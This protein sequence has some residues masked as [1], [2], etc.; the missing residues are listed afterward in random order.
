MT[1]PDEMMSG[2]YYNGDTENTM[3]EAEMMSA[4]GG[5]GGRGHGYGGGHGHGHACKS[6]YNLLKICFQC[7]HSLTFNSSLWWILGP[8]HNFGRIS[9]FNV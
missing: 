6:T 2:S 5:G 9:V 3:A 1:V 8:F 7:T 4:S